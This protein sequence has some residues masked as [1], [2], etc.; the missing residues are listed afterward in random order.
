MCGHLAVDTE[1]THLGEKYYTLHI[2]PILAHELG[3]LAEH[4][5]ALGLTSPDG[6][7]KTAPKGLID[8]TG[9]PCTPGGRKVAHPNARHT[10]P[11]SPHLSPWW[12]ASSSPGAASWSYTMGDANPVPLVTETR[13]VHGDHHRLFPR[14]QSLEIPG[15]KRAVLRVVI[16]EGDISEDGQCQCSSVQTSLLLEPRLEARDGLGLICHSGVRL[17]GWH[18]VHLACSFLSLLGF[19]LGFAAHLGSHPGWVPLALSNSPVY[20]ECSTRCW[21]LV[22]FIA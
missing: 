11:A 19:A 22:W 21:L 5:W 4:C 8:W 20:Y 9:Q 14:A 2:A 10:L 18:S 15:L 1:G 13:S 7:T 16:L 6:R 17:V 12:P 3:Q